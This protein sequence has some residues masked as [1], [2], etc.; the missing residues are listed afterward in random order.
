MSS[1]DEWELTTVL[2]SIK[3]VAEHDESAEESGTDSEDS[4]VDLPFISD[5]RATAIRARTCLVD[6]A[7]QFGDDP[8]KENF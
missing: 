8:S 4:S 5:D 3:F 1:D 2:D 7:I 6:L